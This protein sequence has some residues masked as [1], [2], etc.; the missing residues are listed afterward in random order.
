MWVLCGAMWPPVPAFFVRFVR[1]CL[2]I[3]AGWVP[4]G[5]WVLVG[6]GRS[7]YEVDA[8]RAM[9]P[10]ARKLYQTSN[11]SRRRQYRKAV[12]IHSVQNRGQ[13]SV[14]AERAMRALLNLSIGRGRGSVCARRSHGTG[15]RFP[16]PKTTHCPPKGNG[17]WR[18]QN[19]QQ[20]TANS[21]PGFAG[22]ALSL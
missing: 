2:Q 3:Q 9:P 8:S 20:P 12:Q 19:S 6:L 4:W 1:V 22:A 5:R 17:Q 15:Q 11:T 13:F 14:Q 21:R 18:G 10:Q 16:L 7:R